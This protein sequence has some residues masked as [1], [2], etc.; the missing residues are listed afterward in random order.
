M[1]TREHQIN[2]VGREV[3]NLFSDNK[4]LLAGTVLKEGTDILL[5]GEYEILQKL[6]DILERE[7]NN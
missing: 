4:H 3:F 6:F 7:L 1:H 2:R 5:E